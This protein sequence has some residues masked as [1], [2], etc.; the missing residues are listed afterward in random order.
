MSGAHNDTPG[1]IFFSFDEE[2][3]LDALVAR[4]VP[5]D[6]QDPGAREAG[7]VTYI[8]RALAGPYA[9]WQLGYREGLRLV[10][11]HAR[12]RHGKGFDELPAADQDAIVAELEAGAVPGFPDGE[13]AAFFGMVWAHTIEGMFCDPAHGG[14][15]DAVGWKIIAFPGAQYGYSA[16]DMTYGKDLSTLRIMTL[17]DIRALA[18]DQPDL[19]Y[20]RPDNRPYPEGKEVPVLPLRRTNPDTGTNTGA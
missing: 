19:F 4:I 8:D 10:G 20:R 11:L 5:G 2:N 1:P 6:E 18:R 15:R 9:Q 13:A 7:V 17:A 14:N 12:S 3:T 16:Q